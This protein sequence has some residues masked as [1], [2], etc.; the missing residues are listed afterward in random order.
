MTTPAVSLDVESVV[1]RYFA[2]VA[3]LASTEDELLDVLDPEVRVTELPN[4]LTPAR[5]ARDLDGTL[6][7]F[8]A[9]KA[10]LR[11]Q[12]FDVHEV[13]VDGERAAV[14]GTWSGT[15][16]IDAGG[17]SA[18]TRLVAHIAAFL[19]VRDGRVVEHS[20]YD[21]YEPFERRLPAS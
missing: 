20:T 6:A 14:R 15:V 18:G 9:G 8:R 10:L 1:R 19:T 11:E 3:D 2:T 17:F 16:G 4:L 12:A 13:L 7:G 5:A 21:C